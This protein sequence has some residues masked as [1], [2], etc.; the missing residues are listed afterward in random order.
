MKLDA[1]DEISFNNLLLK[2]R[3]VLRLWSLLYAASFSSIHYSVRKAM[4]RIGRQFL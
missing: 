4:V 3:R 1:S 2:F